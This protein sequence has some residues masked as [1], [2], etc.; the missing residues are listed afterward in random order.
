MTGTFVF[1]TLFCTSI[2]EYAFGIIFKSRNNDFIAERGVA[3]KGRESEINLKTRLQIITINEIF[4]R[5]PWITCNKTWRTVWYNPSRGANYGLVARAASRFKLYV[6]SWPLVSSNRFQNKTKKLYTILYD[7]ARKQNPL[8]TDNATGTVLF[9]RFG[10][11][12]GRG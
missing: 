6:N 4:T 12:V 5:T 9:G 11:N 10:H 2:H 8:P 1:I 7:R 3:R